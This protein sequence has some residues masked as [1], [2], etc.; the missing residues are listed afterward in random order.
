MGKFIFKKKIELK[1]GVELDTSDFALQDK[2]G[3]IFQWTYKGEENEEAITVK[4]GIFSIS[5]NS[6]TSDLDL[7][8]TS[9]NMSKHIM[10]DYVHTKDLTTKIDQFFSK[11]H[12]YEKYGVFPKRGILM[13]G[14][15]GTGKSLTISKTV[16]KYVE[17]KDTAVIY[18][19]T[20]KFRASDV[21]I[22]LK[23]LQYD[24][25]TAKVIFVIEDI[26]GVSVDG[27]GQKLAVE[28]SLLSILDNVESIFKIPTMILATTN[29]PENLLANIANRPKRFDYLHKVDNPSADYRKAFLD[30]FSQ[31]KANE[32]ELKEIQDKKYS[33]FSIAHIEEVIIR[34]E[35]DD[36]TIM[37][38]LHKVLEQSK[39]AAN[40]FAPERTGIRVV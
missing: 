39:L 34:H 6:K 13:Y 35:L 1:E 24:P 14:G 20:D 26:G 10:E 28:P 8:P 40:S 16:A 25:S 29:F 3:D 5:F 37:E 11:L 38:S 17:G 31:G 22:F 2:N 21:K 12:I 27:G 30:F 33:G 7:K 32:E 19:P 36:I 4:P 23:N 15:Q 9:F 18:W